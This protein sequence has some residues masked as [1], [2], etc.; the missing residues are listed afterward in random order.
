[1]PY[2]NA[3]VMDPT[4]PLIRLRQELT[5]L[6]AELDFVK[7]QRDKFFNELENIPEAIRAHGFV[8]LRVEHHDPIIL[9]EKPR[10]VDSHTKGA[11]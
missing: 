7:N 3:N 11:S 1:M 9:I 10:D 6:R 8:D 2:T 5:A 4:N